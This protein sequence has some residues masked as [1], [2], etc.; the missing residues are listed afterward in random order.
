MVKLKQHHESLICH[1]NFQNESNNINVEV[2]LFESY[3]EKNRDRFYEYLY[4]LNE[5][6]NDEALIDDMSQKLEKYTIE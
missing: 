5:D 6:V 1:G 2:E 4:T 3:L